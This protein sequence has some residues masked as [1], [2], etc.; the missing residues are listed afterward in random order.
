MIPEH[1]TTLQMY[2]TEDTYLV[3]ES[4]L[5]KIELGSSACALLKELLHF[6]EKSTL[7]PSIKFE[8][9]R[10][11]QLKSRVVNSEFN[12]VAKYPRGTRTNVE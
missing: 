10:T 9:R 4:I 11:Y 3:A 2:M 5:F 12:S 8:E 6:R 1:V 7:V